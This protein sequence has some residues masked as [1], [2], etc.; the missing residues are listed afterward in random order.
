V[1]T[2]QSIQVLE[3]SSKHFSTKPDGNILDGPMNAWVTYLGYTLEG[4][5]RQ[6]G[7][8]GIIDHNGMPSFEKK[9]QG[10]GRTVELTAG[11]LGKKKVGKDFQ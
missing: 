2:N 11:W 7:R 10:K 4:N 3:N 9:N 6:V 8:E 5:I 1:E